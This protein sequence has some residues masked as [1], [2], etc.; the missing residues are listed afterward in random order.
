MSATTNNSSPSAT[1]TKSQ[2]KRKR[3]PPVQP[4]RKPKDMPK[5]YLSAYNLFYKDE[6]ER[7][8]KAG[9]D[10]KNKTNAHGS[11]RPLSEAGDGGKLK[12]E[13]EEVKTTLTPKLPD[14][15][16]PKNN[17]AR[18]HAR[19]SGIGFAN[20]TRIVAEKW[21]K[22]DP[23]LKAPYE[24]VAAQDKERYRKQML[25]WRAKEKAKSEAGATVEEETTEAY[26]AGS[27]GNTELYD[28]TP[29]EPERSPQE[30]YRNYPG[31]YHGH[32]HFLGHTYEPSGSASVPITPQ[33]EMSGTKPVSDVVN[34]KT[35]TEF[36]PNSDS[37]Q[38]RVHSF[39]SS[40]GEQGTP[41][42]YGYPP[43]YRGRWEAYERY[44]GHRMGS[45][46]HHTPYPPSTVGMGGYA[47]PLGPSSMVH[48][49][50]AHGNPGPDSRYEYSYGPPSHHHHHY[51]RE[52]SSYPAYYTP[53]Q[54]AHSNPHGNPHMHPD[55]STPP[56]YHHN[57]VSRPPY[58]YG[59]HHH[60]AYHH[61]TPTTPSIREET[62]QLQA[63]RAEFQNRNHSSEPQ[64]SS[65]SKDNS[66]S[67][68]HAPTT[69]NDAKFSSGT[70]NDHSLLTSLGNIDSN[71]DT[72]TVDFLTTL[73]L[74]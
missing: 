43:D 3:R 38:R 17:A 35:G 15:N 20:L 48:P 69:R 26:A 37:L 51:H 52:Y 45:P 53:P 5:R 72:E 18:K 8:L 57:D 12:E 70:K 16:A 14:P 25:V 9:L 31:N 74:E 59:Y 71:L 61:S 40:H 68:K 13:K 67:R 63:S 19:S 58:T 30:V 1:S 55:F 50:R 54:S 60:P 41:P 21:K 27:D 22:L 46:Y 32:H 64:A 29:T 73:D 62:L 65:Q 33:K 23:A 47:V 4:W 42:V 10:P 49:A 36:T 6:R 34:A 39:D 24:E 2:L 66:P 7:M 44:Q 28:A 11:A 56:Y